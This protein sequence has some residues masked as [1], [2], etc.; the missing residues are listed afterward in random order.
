MRIAYRHHS[1]H[2]F[3]RSQTPSDDDKTHRPHRGVLES[4]Y[5]AKSCPQSAAVL[6]HF[7]AARGIQLFG[8]L[9]N[10]RPILQKKKLIVCKF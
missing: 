5:R 7:D 10:C 8:S 6:V 4:N 3:V 9:P 1:G 2:D